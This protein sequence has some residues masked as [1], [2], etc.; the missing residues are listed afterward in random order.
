MAS[1][2]LPSNKTITTIVALILSVGTTKVN[3]SDDLQLFGV[4]SAT[5]IN[6]NSPALLGK[7]GTSVLNQLVLNSTYDVSSSL[8]LTGAVNIE[9]TPD[10]TEA[11][12]DYASANYN[13][14][15]GTSNEL[16]VRVGRVKYDIGLYDSVKNNPSTQQSIILP[17]ATYW[18]AFK[19]FAQS[20]DGGQVELQHNLGK[21]GTVSLSST[22][23]NAV[24]PQQSEAG[25]FYG[26]FHTPLSGSL[27]V[28][29]PIISNTIKYQNMKWLL[30]YNKTDMLIHRDYDSVQHLPTNMP[31]DFTFAHSMQTIGMSYKGDK[32]WSS[33]EYTKHDLP[34]LPV[35]IS[36]RVGWIL[37]PNTDVIVSY[38]TF[39]HLNQH[40]PP[41]VPTVEWKR[42]GREYSIG[43]NH[44]INQTMD[45][46]IEYHNGHGVVWFPTSATS[47]D[48][49]LFAVSLVYKFNVLK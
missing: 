41:P 26:Y 23:G 27:S 4:Y 34:S 6:T 10:G 29:K 28:T 13:I 30:Q 44:R 1:N 21:Y 39:D 12:L 45:L 19:H 48:W 40:V 25:I 17:L 31:F 49:N 24:I 36:G 9:S 33:L 5:V 43:I 47:P 15:I 7:E 46:K 38:S 14:S 11:S 20:I 35:G 3:A 2:A 42:I 22:Y 18:P 8:M 37:S 16:N 32:C